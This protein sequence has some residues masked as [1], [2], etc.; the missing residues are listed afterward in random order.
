MQLLLGLFGQIRPLIRGS[1][2]RQQRDLRSTEAALEHLLLG[3]GYFLLWFVT[4]AE[5]VPLFVQCP[6]ELRCHLKRPKTHA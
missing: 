3:Q 5:V 6:A 4:V 2:H 1:L